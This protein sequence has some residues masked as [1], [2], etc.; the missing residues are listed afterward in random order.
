M[1]FFTVIYIAPVNTLDEWMKKSETERQ[2]VEAKMRQDWDGWLITHK[3]AVL[4][5]V[6]FGVTK[7]VSKNGIEDVRNGMMLSSYVAGESLQAVA[8]LFT[9]H[10][11]LGIPG[12][13]IEI[14]EARPMSGVEAADR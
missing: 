13:T 2:E 6:G 10:P 8:E 5:T 4:N 1:K 9:D 3:D 11:H 14:M 12:A 7:R